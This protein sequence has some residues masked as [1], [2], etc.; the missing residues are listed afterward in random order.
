MSTS[1]THLHVENYQ[2]L[3]LADLDLAQV[4]II[5][6]PRSWGKSALLRALNALL[7]NQTGSDFIRKGEKECVVSVTLSD[8]VIVR[9]T[10]TVNSAQYEI[11][12]TDGPPSVYEKLAGAVPQDVQDILN[13][14]PIEVD[15]TFSITPQIH[16][17]FDAPL[18]MLESPG[19][20]ARALARTTKLDGIMQVQQIASKDLR[21]D[22]ATIKT[23]DATIERLDARLEELPDIDALIDRLTTAEK[24]F[25]VADSRWQYLGK[26]EQRVVDYEGAM[27]AS[28]LSIPGPGV[29]DSI[30]VSLDRLELAANTYR[31]YVRTNMAISLAEQEHTVAMHDCADT[32]QEIDAVLG[33]MKVCPVC[34]KAM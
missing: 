12:W 33:E 6:G 10:K 13:I 25:E 24:V 30:D 15:K 7:T 1:I 29:L 22:R 11:L 31:K 5:V 23:S 18:L 28:K 16:E 9:W 19:R 32:E 8:G 27:A 20:I 3:G 21:T 34:G 17:Q 2:S 4:N 14:H 26:A